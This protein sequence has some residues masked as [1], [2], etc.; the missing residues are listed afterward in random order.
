MRNLSV[1]DIVSDGVQDGASF[2]EVLPSV[3]RISRI[4]ADQFGTLRFLDVGSLVAVQESGCHVGVQV[5]AQVSGC[6]VGVQESGCQVGAQV[7]VQGP[8]VAG[9]GDGRNTAWFVR[10]SL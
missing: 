6:H 5:T 10:G 9:P 4:A 7:S 3:V 1:L 8:C 2:E